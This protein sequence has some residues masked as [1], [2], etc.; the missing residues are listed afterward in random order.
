M[1][2]AYASLKT[3][4]DTMIM[5]GRR[6]YRPDGYESLRDT[7]EIA[8]DIKIPLFDIYR[9]KLDCNTN[10]IGYIAT[11]M[12]P[13]AKVDDIPFGI[14]VDGDN[15]VYSHAINEDYRSI[16][17]DKQ[18]SIYICEV[19]SAIRGIIKQDKFYLGDKE[20]RTNMLVAVTRALPFYLTFFHFKA[21]LSNGSISGDPKIIGEKAS[22][23]FVMI[24]EKYITNT[25]EDA[26]ALLE[27]LLNKNNTFSDDI[28]II[29][30]QMTFNNKIEL[31]V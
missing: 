5:G 10:P 18:I 7:Y 31:F 23:A 3:H 14:M 22:E 16:I 28:S 24:L 26:K 19:Y 8:Y 29:Y 27:F 17:T 2:T 11:L 4:F 13:E 12:G 25:E 21:I 1:K 6:R 30:R 20:A 9:E 15:I